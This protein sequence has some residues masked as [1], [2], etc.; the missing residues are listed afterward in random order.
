MIQ[1]LRFNPAEEALAEGDVRCEVM[2]G[3][4]IACFFIKRAWYGIVMVYATF[5]LAVA[6]PFIKTPF[7]PIYLIGGMATSFFLV[8]QI[9]H[10]VKYIRFRGGAITVSKSGVEVASAAGSGKVPAVDIT[11]LEHN[12]L[13]NLVIRLKQGGS[14]SF[15]MAL[16]SEKDRG[17]LIGLFQDMA[18]R[19]TVIH[20]KIWEFIEAITVAA[21]L[22]V[23]IIQYII[24]AYYIPT[25]SMEDTL[26]EGDHLF[27]EKITYGPI[28]PKMAFMDRPVHLTCLAIR[29]VQ[30]GDIVI[31]RPP[32]DEDKDYIKRC[33]A[34][35]G[36]KFEI[37]NGKV[38]INDKPINEPYVKGVTRPFNFGPNSQN[39]IEGVVPKGKIVVLGDNREN[40]QDS[41]WF[42]Y[43]DIE[44][45][46]G[47]A[48]IKYWNT[49]QILNCDFD[50]FGLIR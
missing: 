37:R 13:G 44:R 33:I 9:N 27:V 40:S 31:F 50:R 15:P 10:I 22:A 46:K 25:G 48:L 16:L 35:P 12:L 38:Y 4:A 36:D 41:R 29:G 8:R 1:F 2:S 3:K 17:R 6:V 23:H 28:I 45:I 7:M 49:R 30:R 21:F 42:G 43:L 20:R 47:K 5:F 34:I 39:E 11:Y 24:Q 18:P 32:H 19:R 14:V 26:K